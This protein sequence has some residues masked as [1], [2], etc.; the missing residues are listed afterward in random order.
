MARVRLGRSLFARIFASF[1]GG[2]LLFVLLSL[3]L[4]FLNSRSHD[5]EWVAEVVEMAEEGQA[6]A[7]E[8]RTER[9]DVA[10]AIYCMLGT[11]EIDYLEGRT[12]RAGHAFSRAL[13]QAEA[14]RFKVESRY[15]TRLITVL[16][17]GEG[18][19]VN[20]P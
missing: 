7:G 18:F 5:A 4:V 2:V 19:P 16:K 3:A 11:G 20:L 1:V 8:V 17:S 10:A 6:V 12:K 13:K 9:P 15:A 14:Y